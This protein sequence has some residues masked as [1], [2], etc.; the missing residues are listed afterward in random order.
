M[1]FCMFAAYALGL[2][3]G[4][5]RVSVGAYTGGNVVSVFFASIMASFAVGLVS[6]EHRTADRLWHSNSIVFCA[7]LASAEACGYL[8]QLLQC[9][10]W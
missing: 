3:Y 5:Y 9:D 8:L 2:F 7:G 6:G 10:V 1:Q 4:A